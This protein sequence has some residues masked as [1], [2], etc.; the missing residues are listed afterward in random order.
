MSMRLRPFLLAPCLAVL[1]MQAAETL[2]GLQAHVAYPTGTFGDATHLDR[3][4]GF[5]LGFQVPIDFG[6]GHVLRPKLD[7][8]TFNRDRE[9][10][11]YK[12]DSLMLLVDY[13]YYLEEQREGA[14]F[15]AGLG[16][17]STRRDV[18]RVSTLSTQ[19]H[20]GSSTGL[21][22]NVG[23]G[24]AFTRNV[25]LEVK[26]LGVDL[27]NINFKAPAVDSGFMGNSVAA[28]LSFTF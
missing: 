6:A 8:L 16:M 7:Y 23:M 21:C 10:T 14:Y 17:H 18:A 15:I 5:G 19:S 2:F 28:S 13:N 25:A 22:Y 24:F 12:A 26:Y 27:G 11:R 4:V 3:R 20:D 9:G 1:P